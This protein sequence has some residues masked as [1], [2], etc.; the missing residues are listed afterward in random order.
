MRGKT[1]SLCPLERRHLENTRAWANDPELMRFLD[2]A[3]SVTPDQHQAWFENLQN[4]DDRAYFAIEA[5]ADSQHIG[6]IWL[7]DIKLR[8]HK[9]EVRIVIGDRGHQ[10]RGAGTE[11]ISLLSEYA[12]ANLNLHKV[13]AFVLGINPRARRAFEKAGFVLEATLRDD[14]WVDDQPTDVY[15]LGKLR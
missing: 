9:A 10:D 15:L 1:V 14:R 7:W 5:N 11:A 13:Y 6:N 8:H 3:H 12:F 2:R 4:H